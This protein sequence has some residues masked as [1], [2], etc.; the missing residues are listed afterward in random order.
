MCFMRAT[1][2]A[3]STIQRGLRELASGEA[4]AAT[5]TRK[6]GGGRKRCD[7]PRSPGSR[8]LDAITS[9]DVRGLMR[10]VPTHIDSL[11]CE[12]LSEFCVRTVS[13]T[14][15]NP[16][17]HRDLRGHSDAHRCCGKSLMESALVRVGVRN[18]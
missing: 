7:P 10:R 18:A 5:R 12:V 14:P 16:V 11:S 17:K 9:E 2:I 15:E 4:L 8:R 3:A 13:D 1:G 6:A